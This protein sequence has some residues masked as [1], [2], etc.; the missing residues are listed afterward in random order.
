MK[1]EK[2]GDVLDFN[3]IL[4]PVGSQIL[5]VSKEVSIEKAAE[6]ELRQE[7][8]ELI[9]RV[10]KFGL[11]QGQLPEF[12]EISTLNLTLDSLMEATYTE[13]KSTRFPT[14]NT[15]DIVVAS[16]AGLIAVIIDVTL[17]G[18]PEVVKI[19]REGERFDGSVLTKAIREM[20]EGPIS[21]FAEQLSKICKVPYDMSAVKGSMR[22]NNHRLRSLAH[23][24]FFGIFFAIFDIVCGT[25]TF[26]D[27]SGY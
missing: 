5:E 4:V 17:V 12:P 6:Q 9:E 22:P 27:N 19:Y 16:V 11:A 15:T 10:K 18:T 25:T 21:G 1:G 24:P 3:E 7:L 20:T 8:N 2:R 26:V 14:L 13:S 23:D